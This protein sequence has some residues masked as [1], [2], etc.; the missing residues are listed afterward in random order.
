MLRRRVQPVALGLGLAGTLLLLMAVHRA[1][2]QDIPMDA[3]VQFGP[4]H[5][6][7]APPGNHV[8]DPNEVTIRRG[9]T[10]TFQV[11]GGGHG[12]AIYE[13]E[14]KTTRADI[15]ADLCPNGPGG[16]CVGATADPAREI[17]DADAA[18]VVEIE[19]FRGVPSYDYAPGSLL[20]AIGGTGVFLNGSTA[21]T[22]PAPGVRLAHRFTDSGRF[23]VICMNR[24]HAV[25]DYMF[26]FVN[27]VP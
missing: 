23:L 2:A 12:V 16:P 3:V 1:Y 21:A 10:V 11:N 24:F 9:G 14:A 6:Q 13:V 4:A 25:N 20:R 8:L 19:A 22:P 18:V 5:P 15:I 7:P 27:V 26:G 17:T